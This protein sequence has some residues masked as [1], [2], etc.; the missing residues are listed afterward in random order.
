MAHCY[1]HIPFCRERCSYCD[2]FLVPGTRLMEPFFDALLQETEARLCEFGSEPVASIHFGGG[3][4]S[5]AGPRRIGRWLALFSDRVE[6]KGDAEI[7]LEA[8]PEDCRKHVME[9]FRTLGINRVSLGVQ[10]FSGRKLERLGRKHTPDEACQVM[11]EMLGLFG[12]VSLDL[13]CGVPDEDMDEWHAD[14]EA[15][16][17]LQPHHISV[18]MLTVEAGTKLQREIHRG[19]CAGPDEG[20]QAEAYLLAVERLTQEGFMHYEVSNF[21]RPGYFSRYNSGS[22][23]REPYIGLGPSAHTLLKDGSGERRKANVA[24]LVRYISA[25]YDASTGYELLTPEERQTEEVFLS[26]RLG[27]GIALQQLQVIHR[28]R[29]Q[30]LEGMLEKFMLEGFLEIRRG[31][32]RLTPR[33]F[34]FSDH[35]T[36]TLL[37]S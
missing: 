26:L 27:Q 19:R 15:A 32:V 31:R 16:I 25:P 22:W 11:Q 3:T 24:S 7:T 28:Q 34:L 13:I 30:W 36:Q 20:F 10:S 14:L 35:I 4:P 9:E 8:N 37:P 29:A 23:R 5:L 17:S 18:Y 6:I 21:A 2:F 33:G 12:N 1:V